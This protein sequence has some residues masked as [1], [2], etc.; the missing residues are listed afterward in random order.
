MS[1]TLLDTRRLV[2]TPE[3]VHL[4]LRAAGPVPRFLAWSIDFLI[5]AAAYFILGT[6]LSA[7]GRFG[8]GLFLILLFL[9]E[10]FYPVLFEVYRHGQTPGKRVMGLRVLQDNGAPVGWA[11][12]VIRNLLRVV[13]FF[14]FLYAFGV[15]TMLAHRDFKRLGD[16]A[17]G[18]LVVH[19]EPAAQGRKLPAAGPLPP[20]L[21]LALDEQR[22]VVNF[23]ERSESLTWQRAEELAGILELLTGTEGDAGVRRLHQYANWL[24]GNR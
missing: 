23:A 17:A 6:L 18:T 16:L 14:P 15:V 20:P 1:G 24:Q 21:K 8:V 19:V 5:R 9:L 4:E 2:E 12:S 7:F 22:A 11:G 3:G 13:D 10:W